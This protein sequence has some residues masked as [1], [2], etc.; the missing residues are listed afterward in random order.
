MTPLTPTTPVRW[1]NPE[2][3]GW[4]T[5]RIVETP[6]GEIIDSRNGGSGERLGGTGVGRS[7]SAG[8]RCCLHYGGAMIVTGD[9]RAADLR[10]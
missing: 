7:R 3:G 2:T 1:K 8:S 5:G 4:E 6:E 10:D 9:S